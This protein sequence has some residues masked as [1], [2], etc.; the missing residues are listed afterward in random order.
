MFDILLD[1]KQIAFWEADETLMRRKVDEFDQIGD[2]SKRSENW[3]IMK[4]YNTS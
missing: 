2:E 4:C 1:H 3:K